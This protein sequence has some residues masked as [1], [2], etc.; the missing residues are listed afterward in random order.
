LKAQEAWR[1][2]YETILQ[3]TEDTTHLLNTQEKL[4]KLRHLIVKKDVPTR[5]LDLGEKEASA[6]LQHAQQALGLYQTWQ[7]NLRSRIT[8]LEKDQ[9]NVDPFAQKYAA[10]R[11]EAL[12]RTGKFG[13]E[14]LSTLL[15][16][17][18]I[19]GRLM[20]E[21]TAHG[22]RASLWEKALSSGSRL[23]ELWNLELWVIDDR[24]VTIRKIA[25][26]L[27]ILILG[28]IVVKYAIRLLAMRLKQTKMEASAAAAAEKLLLYTGFLLIVLFAL[29]TVN[30]PLTAFTFLGGAIAIGLGF[31]AQN[32]IN[33]FISGFIIMAERPIRI[34]DLIELEGKCVRVE[35][36]GAR[37]TRVKTA[38]NIHI[39]VPNSSFL[40]KNI[41]NWTLSDQMIR[42]Q[43]SVGVAYGSP[44]TQVTGLLLQAADQTTFV[45]KEPKPYVIFNDFGDN[46][47]IFELFF[48][49]IVQGVVERKRMAS[50][51]RYQIN[52]LLSK[53]AITI[54]FPQR[55]IHM[56]SVRPLQVQIVEPRR[57]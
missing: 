25:T 32:L 29:R 57:E 48:W 51:V 11:L 47:L 8:A 30:I 40:E 38:E 41:V 28:I 17:A 35:E 9:G 15:A 13:G 1:E 46:A 49:V 50:D 22:N 4:W 33:N 20:D 2:A 21:I 54:A 44:V 39:L 52:A 10:Y 12:N 53:H 18:Q 23:D 36:I 26:A 27:V 31:G 7:V 19:A 42:V 43:V 16:T 24:G 6:A 5:E 56:D 34:G 37:C 14:Y 3:Q 45:L 55:D